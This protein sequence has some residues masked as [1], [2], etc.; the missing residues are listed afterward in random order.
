MTVRSRPSSLRWL[1][2]AVLSLLA[3]VLLIALAPPAQAAKKKPGHRAQATARVPQGF[4][5]TVLG[6]PV[7][8]GMATQPELGAQFDTMVASG[9]ESVRVVFDWSLAQPYKTWS[10]VPA[11]Q[12]GN[13][14]SDGIDNVPTNWTVL[15]DL[16]AAAAT[17]HLSLL[18]VV[19]GAP[20][21]D[22]KHYTDAAVSIPR[23]DDG[24]AAF[25]A[26]LAHRYGRGGTYWQAFSPIVPI[27]AWQIWNEPNLRGFWPIQPFAR[28]Y[29]TLLKTA[30]TAIKREDPKAQIVLAGLANYSWAALRSIY[31]IPGARRLFDVVGL[32]PYTRTPQ[33]VLTILQYGRD[34]MKAYGD[35]TKPIIADEISWPSSQGKTVHTTGY[36]FATTEKGQARNVG[37]VIPLLAAARNKLRLRAIYYYTWAT[38][39]VPHGLAFTYAGLLKYAHQQF[40]RKPVFY[41]FTSAALAA[42]RCRTK[43]AVATV[44]AKATASR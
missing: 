21:W 43:G 29:V 17:R 13:F 33:G 27:T 30:R 2:V 34:V 40:V 18:P 11:D 42:E 31:K 4:V 32:H 39:E 7:F 37:A 20:S 22:G 35:A 6:D 12:A 25:C 36:D 38:V 14:S 16:V 1:P 44:C 23:H 15:D 9:V 5:G 24:F 8:P 41:T 3:V 10:Q 28:S 19:I 26:A